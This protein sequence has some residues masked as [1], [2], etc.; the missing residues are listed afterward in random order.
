MLLETREMLPLCD[1]DKGVFVITLTSSVAGTCSQQPL[2][3]N[4]AATTLSALS[5]SSAAVDKAASSQLCACM[6]C[7]DLVKI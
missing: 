2:E 1:A 4:G 6:I 5:N 7:V 3:G